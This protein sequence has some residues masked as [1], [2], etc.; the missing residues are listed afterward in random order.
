MDRSSAT[1]KFSVNVGETSTE[2]CPICAEAALVLVTYVFGPTLPAF[3]RC[4]ATL[5]ELTAK[6]FSPTAVR[7][8]LLAGHPRKQLNFTWNGLE[9][10]EESLRRMTDFLGRVEAIASGPAHP[11]VSARVKEAVDGFNAA[12]SDDLNTAAGLAAIAR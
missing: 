7:Y 6:G 11:A 8:A 3:G 1:V 12:L 9:Q 10:A 2:P 4:V 5:D